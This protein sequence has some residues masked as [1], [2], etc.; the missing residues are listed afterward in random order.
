MRK[1]QCLLFVLKWSCICYY[2]IY[3]TVPLNYLH[4]S[5]Q[6]FIPLWKSIR[7]NCIFSLTNRIL[8]ISRIFQ[9]LQYFLQYAL[10]IFKIKI[11]DFA[12]FF[13]AATTPWTLDVSWTYIGHIQFISPPAVLLYTLNCWNKFISY[14]FIVIRKSI[15]TN[16]L[17]VK[18]ETIL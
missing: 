5:R 7:Y 17:Q 8:E 9:Y 12:S 4:Y 11:H 13:R 14:K 15:N 18:S 3:M 10:Q 16:N 2:L 6:I 1:F